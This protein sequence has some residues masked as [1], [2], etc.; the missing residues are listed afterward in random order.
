MSPRERAEA[1]ERAAAELV[2]RSYADVGTCWGLARTLLGSIGVELPADQAEALV[3]EHAIVLPVSPGEAA[4][5]GDL[6]VMPGGGLDEL[7]V[8]V[9]L[10]AWRVVH[11]A[12]ESGVVVHQL[13]ALRRAGQVNRLVRPILLAVIRRDRGGG[14]GYH[15]CGVEIIVVE[16]PL[17]RAERTRATVAVPEGGRSVREEVARIT[18]GWGDVRRAIAVDGVALPEGK[19]VVLRGGETVCVAPCFGDPVD[20]IFIAI[21]L[22]SAVASSV[23]ARPRLPA[24]K[25]GDAE[26]KRYGFSRFSNEAFAGEVIPVVLGRRVRYGGKVIAAIPG[27]GVDGGGDETLRMLICLGHGPIKAI[28][29]QEADFDRVAAS[30]IAGV[31]LNDQPLSSFP[32]C[33][34]SGRLG[35]DDQ[36]VIRGFDDTETLREVG[37]GGAALRN[38]SGSERTGGSPSGEA[39]TYSTAGVVHDV[40]LRVRLARGLYSTSVNAQLEP[41]EVSYRYRSRTTAG[42]GAW[43][44]WTVVTLEKARQSE[45]FSAPRVAL[46]APG[47]TPV[48]HDIQ[49]ERVSTEPD[50]ALSVD[51]LVWDSV[52]ETIDAENTYAGFAVLA[53]ELRASEQLTGLPRVSV[54]V[55]G[56]ADLRIWDGISDPSSPVFTSGYSDNPADHALESLTNTT[57][58]MGAV[59]T[60]ASV[61][62]AGL[63]SWRSKCAAAV[64]RPAGGTR[65]RFTCNIVL[66]EDRDGVEWLRTICR[67]G[68]CVPVTSGAVWD[69]VCDDVQASPAERF[70][71]GSIAVDES[72]G[73]AKFEYVRD[74]AAGGSNRPNQLVLQFENAEQDGRVDTLV[75]PQAGELWLGGSEPE[76][77]NSQAVRLD[78]VTDPD[79]AASELV[80]EMK[81]T[82]GL[83]R[84]VTFATSRDAVV[85][86]P[87]ERFDV[88]FDLPGWGLASGRCESGCTTTDLHLDRTVTLAEGAA[89]VL[90]VLHL[91]GSVELAEV[92]SPAGTYVGGPDGDA[93]AIA[94][95]LAQAPGL[96]AE[97]AVGESGVEMKPFTCTAVRLRSSEPREWEV[98]GLEYDDDVYDDSAAEVTLPDYSSLRSVL[99]PP[100][101]VLDLRASERLS[102]GVRVVTL[103]WRQSSADAQITASFKIYRRIV[104]TATWILVPEPTIAARGAVLE[105][106]DLD[107]GYELA[108]VAVSLGGS[109]LSPEDV[110]VLKAILVF[111]LSAEPPPPPSGLML[112]NTGGNTYTLS[113]DEV[114]DAEGYQVLFGGDATGLPNGGAED[115]L[116]LARTA[117]TELA[118]LE[119]P[120]GQ[121]CTFW[122]RSVGDNGRLSWTA[123]SVTEATPATPAGETIKQTDTFDL[124]SDGTLTNLTY[125]GTDS[126]LE[127]DSPAS[128]GVWLSPVMDTGSATLTELTLRPGTRND[129]DDPTILAVAFGVPGIEADQWGIVSLSP[130]VVGMLMPP[131]PD[132]SHGWTFE[133]K[134]DDGATWTAWGEISPC[135]S[136]RRVI[137]R[138]QVRV[139]MAR[140][141]T[142][143]R[144]ALGGL[145]VVATH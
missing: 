119:L 104:G 7:H 9:C 123:A 144:P 130:K 121:S 21:A 54:D 140:M 58:G 107:R 40:T 32:G 112:T 16:D 90:R 136:I 36:D 78:G 19:D 4:Q 84:S 43:S 27:D 10:D 74:L 117:A 38:T 23:L 143:Y 55:R 2:G 52:V 49:V 8:G 45:F 34:A 88:A 133:V 53:L 108:V 96:G 115:C 30:A 76:P 81:R 42:P 91:D 26:E 85:V 137:R 87:G 116:V 80:Y 12:R 24:A 3:S 11:A 98:S 61:N 120:P 79:Q 15:Q 132:N 97:Y 129:A 103:S 46:V 50:D 6:V 101:P 44:A 51:D 65:D 25:G 125:N 122:V 67:T 33:V 109:H 29:D 72:S 37:V 63:L 126:R 142:P 39:V 134:T 68:R 47:G 113:W 22:V 111:G 73:L 100:G 35:A 77:V 14:Y 118:G 57:W 138:Y 86:R 5:A 13:A 20:A 83:T 102:G 69:F 66:D 82:R 48:A 18:S 75:Y 89:Y 127:L 17:G 71:D 139:T 59:Y 145:T 64:D 99:V 60:D 41:R 106:V 95:T 128:P 105:I 124:S 1:I 114:E 94:G 110:R 135:A 28:G 131:W 56:Y 31:Y 93:V 92:S 141:R 62:F 70:T